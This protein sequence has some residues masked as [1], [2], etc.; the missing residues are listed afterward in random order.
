MFKIRVR[1]H[2]NVLGYNLIM[3]KKSQR[4]QTGYLFVPYFALIA[5][6]VLKCF[7][8]HS[9]RGS[10]LVQIN[11]YLRLI[12]ILKVDVKI[13]FDSI[14]KLAK[15]EDEMEITAKSGFLSF[16]KIKL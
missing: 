6:K 12:I 8:Y 2:R 14:Q 5:L 11:I 10:F 4:D 1:F 3:L 7:G 13:Q 16:L 9:I 15:N